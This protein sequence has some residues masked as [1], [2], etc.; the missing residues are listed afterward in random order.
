MIGRYISH[1]PARHFKLVRYNGFL[2]NRKR[3]T[4]LTK[5][6]E[7]L[8]KEERKKTEAPVIHR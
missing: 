8:E 4:L 2:S 3:G 5:V 1:I 7:A 6:Y